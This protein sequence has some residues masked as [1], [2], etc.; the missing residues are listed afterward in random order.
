MGKS[1]SDLVEK[2]WFQA[3]KNGAAFFSF[4]S[5]AGDMIDPFTDSDIV[6]VIK[7]AD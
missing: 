5:C 7:I 4:P 2:H 6:R 3:G 1:S